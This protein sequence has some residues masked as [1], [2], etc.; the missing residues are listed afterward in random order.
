M[1]VIRRKR[2]ASS[3]YGHYGASK[4]EKE[5]GKRKLNR[6]LQYRVVPPP[7]MAHVLTKTEKRKVINFGEK[8]VN[9]KGEI[10]CSMKEEGEKATHHIAI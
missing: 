3:I 7:N 9:K 6:E 2:P 10:I 1:F 5:N 4:R 8:G